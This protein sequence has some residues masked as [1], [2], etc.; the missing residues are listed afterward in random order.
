[1]HTKYIHSGKKKDRKKSNCLGS[2]LHG[3]RN[4]NK[5]KETSKSKWG[6]NFEMVEGKSLM[7]L[8]AKEGSKIF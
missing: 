3:K 2:I 4:Y 6:N 7:K 8:K 1:M 5:M